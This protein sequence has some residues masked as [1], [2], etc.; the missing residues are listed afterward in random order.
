VEKAMN[1]SPE[2][3]ALMAPVRAT[4]RAARFATRFN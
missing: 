4:P 1:K 2:E 3:F